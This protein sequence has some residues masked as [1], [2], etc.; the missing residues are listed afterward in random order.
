LAE[1]EVKPKYKPLPKVHDGIRRVIDRQTVKAQYL[2]SEHYRWQEFARKYG[3]DP[4]A[5]KKADFPFKTWQAEWIQNQGNNIVEDLVPTAVALKRKIAEDRL[6]FPG[7]WGD[8]TEALRIFQAEIYRR[9]MLNVGADRV[10][11]GALEQAIK[12]KAPERIQALQQAPRYFH[13]PST[14]LQILANAARSIQEL[15]LK[16]LLMPPSELYQAAL[17][18]KDADPEYQEAEAELERLQ[19][20]P[21][22][23]IGG[24][25]TPEKMT[26]ILDQWVDQS[27]ASKQATIDA[28]NIPATDEPL[29]SLESE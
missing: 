7:I 25:M 20:I 23:L 3:Y 26:Q 12:D 19:N 15:H 9:H 17:P 6:K 10:I 5:R 4:S 11:A 13:M 8:A 28:E 18:I 27:A 14:E 24:T 29:D 2:S 16:S 21:H 1:A 22:E